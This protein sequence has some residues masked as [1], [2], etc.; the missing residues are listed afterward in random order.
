MQSDFRDSIAR[1]PRRES[2]EKFRANPL[3]LEVHKLV[4]AK[5]ERK[6]SLSPRT[7]A[8]PFLFDVDAPQAGATFSDLVHDQFSDSMRAD[9]DEDVEEIG[10]VSHVLDAGCHEHARQNLRTLLGCRAMGH[11]ANF[12]ELPTPM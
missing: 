4:R 6:E 8:V 2:G 11:S 9:V 1:T 10:L 3:P 7:N 12:P 5:V